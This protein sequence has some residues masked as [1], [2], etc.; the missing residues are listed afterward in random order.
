MAGRQPTCGHNRPSLE[1]PHT[2]RLA[3]KGCLGLP[4]KRKKDLPEALRKELL[5]RRKQ[6]PARVLVAFG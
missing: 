5:G 1:A 6:T 3:L 4:A 2:Y